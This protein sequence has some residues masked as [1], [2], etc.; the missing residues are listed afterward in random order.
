MWQTNKDVAG[1]GG[2][3]ACVVCSF[4]REDDV[5]GIWLRG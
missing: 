2:R 3:C 4:T 1:W 5:A